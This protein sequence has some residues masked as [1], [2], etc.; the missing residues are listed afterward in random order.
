MIYLKTKT[1]LTVHNK[2]LFS[3]N[4]GPKMEHVGHC[5]TK[6]FNSNEYDAKYFH[7]IKF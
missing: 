7:E 5:K 6:T 3:D 2:P 4:L 1:N